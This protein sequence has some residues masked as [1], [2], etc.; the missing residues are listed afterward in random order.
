M[1]TNMFWLKLY[2]VVYFS[3]TAHLLHNCLEQNFVELQGCEMLICK[4][5]SIYITRHCCD[6]HCLHL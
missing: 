4:Q 2:N 6:C 1:I 3:L 5:P